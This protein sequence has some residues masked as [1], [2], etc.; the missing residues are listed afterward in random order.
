MDQFQHTMEPQL[1]QL[2]MRTSL[3][4][5]IVTLDVD[6]QI[7]KKGNKLT[8]EQARLL[9]SE[10]FKLKSI[11]LTN[12]AVIQNI[13]FRNYLKICKPSS[14]STSELGGIKTANLKSS[15]ISK[16]LRALQII[17]TESLKAKA[18]MQVGISR[19]RHLR[20]SA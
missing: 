10:F 11:R 7:C 9:V 18:A 19:R 6:Y 4:K 2:G 14:K 15:K 16:P 1:R 3:K 8:P 17:Q 12:L 13:C 5:G 20:L